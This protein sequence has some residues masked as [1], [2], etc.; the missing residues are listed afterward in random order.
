VTDQGSCSEEH[1]QFA[2]ELTEWKSL[3]RPSN[4]S[5]T[6]RPTYYLVRGLRFFGLRINDFMASFLVEKGKL[7]SL[8]V[9]LRPMSYIEYGSSIEHGFLS[10]IVIGAST[11]GNFSRR[12]GQP[13]IYAHPNLFVWKASS[14]TGCSGALTYDFTWQATRDEHQQAL[15]FDLSCITRIRDCRTPEE[16]LPGAAQ[17]LRDDAA[18][19]LAEMRGEM[20]C[21]TRMARILGRDSDFVNLVRVK[22]LRNADEFVAVDYDVVQRLKGNDVALNNIYHPREY[23]VATEPSVSGPP[24]RLFQVG[25]ERIVFLGRVFDR[26]SVESHCA[27][28]PLTPGTLGATLEGIAA[29]RSGMLGEE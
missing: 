2:I 10:N 1:C 17:V 11:V 13:Q 15:S 19:R 21:D 25:A 8:G 22:H 28:M 16:Y 3:I 4:H 9:G 26:P 12:V 24:Q 29:D 18:K 27:V 7:R 23:A 5:S 14:C 6:E 20:P